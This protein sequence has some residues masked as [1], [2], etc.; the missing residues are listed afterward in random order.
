MKG[1]EPGSLSIDGDASL[2]ALDYI[3]I[4]QYLKEAV[5]FSDI[6]CVAGDVDE[7]GDLSS[8]DYIAMKQ[9]IKN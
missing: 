9:I 7:S 1:A 3:A 5:F 4:K 6:Q 2:S 8:L